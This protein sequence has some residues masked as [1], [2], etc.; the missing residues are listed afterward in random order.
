MS[1]PLGTDTID[2][3]AV[4]RALEELRAELIGAAPDADA[5]EF[6]TRPDVADGS[7]ET[8]HLVVAEQ[9][10]VAARLDLLTERAVEEI[11]EALARLDAGT[12]G[13]CVDC[14]EPI[15]RERLDALP[16]APCCVSCAEARGRGSLI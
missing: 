13:P 14:G 11:D 10:D 1:T 12:Y 9:K 5:Q 3:E 4:R 7:G 15:P 8:E 2:P 6:H 16:A